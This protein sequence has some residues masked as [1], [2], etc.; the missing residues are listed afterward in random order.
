MSSNDDQY[1]RI[2]VKGIQSADDAKLQDVTEFWLISAPGDSTCQQT[3]DALNRAT[4][5]HSGLT[6]NFK[7]HMPDLKVS[8]QKYIV[9]KYITVTSMYIVQGHIRGGAGFRA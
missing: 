4:S 9:N 5:K 2:S 8:T 7:L 3:W 6:T 1:D